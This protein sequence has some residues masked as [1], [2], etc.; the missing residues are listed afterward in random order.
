MLHKVRICESLLHHGLWSVGHHPRKAGL[1]WSD[2]G[3]PRPAAPSPTGEMQTLNHSQR[4]V[5]LGRATRSFQSK[6]VPVCGMG[7]VR[8][9]VE[10][11]PCSSSPQLKSQMLSAAPPT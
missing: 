9:A 8:W 11:P 3:G 4:E 6:H 2:V 1:R 5:T 10:L 7:A